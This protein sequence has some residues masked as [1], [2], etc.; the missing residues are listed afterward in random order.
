M[1]AIPIDLSNS[2][3]CCLLGTV[4]LSSAVACFPMGL[5]M[6]RR[7]FAGVEKE[8]DILFEPPEA[9]FLGLVGMIITL[10]YIPIR[11][12][13]SLTCDLL[14]RHGKR[15]PLT[16]IQTRRE[17]IIR[18]PRRRHGRHRL[19]LFKFPPEYLFHHTA[20][21]RIRNQVYVYSNTSECDFPVDN[22]S[23]LVLEQYPKS[24][25]VATDES[26]LGG[27][28]SFYVDICWMGI[29]SFVFVH[30]GVFQ[31]LW[32]PEILIQLPVII[33]MLA[34]VVFLWCMVGVAVWLDW[35]LWSKNNPLNQSMWEILWGKRGSGDGTAESDENVKL[36]Y[37]AMPKQ[38]V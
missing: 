22:A 34:A 19:I 16:D 1:T 35:C 8:D 31:L 6:P 10:C 9:I 3:R 4:A 25:F 29:C 12:I 15:I 11:L 33:S 30:Y 14:H 37:N 18:P 26:L 2:A 32:G 20:E 23:I 28:L 38:S 7:Q 21:Y 5:A 24:V 13:Q 17:E 27:S 36:S